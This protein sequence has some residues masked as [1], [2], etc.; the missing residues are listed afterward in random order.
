MDIVIS[1]LTSFVMGFVNLLIFPYHLYNFLTLETFKEK[2]SVFVLM[3]QSQ[4]FFYMVVA[5]VILLAGLGVYRRSILRRTVFCLE[6]FSVKIGKIAAWFAIL[7][8]FQQ[9]MIIGMGQIF[10]GNELVF[11]PLGII[12]FEGELQW[13]SGQLKFYN[14]MLIAV[15]SGYT[16]IEGGHVRVDLIYAAT[17]RR[18]QLWIDMIGTL[19]MFIPSTVILWWFAWPLAMNS[20]FS[21]RPLNIW[22]SGARWRDFK[23]ESSGTAEFS[24]VWS[25]KLLI[26]VFAGLMFLTAIAFL[27]RNLLALLEPKED[28]P[29]HYSLEAD[30]EKGTSITGLAARSVFIYDRKKVSGDDVKSEPETKNQTVA[31]GA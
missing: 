4:S 29:S 26:V 1:L 2:M 31:E 8:M 11:A 17:K 28:I 13:F 24:W 16:F 12:L 25:F 27:L 3:G 15:A 9:V 19:G 23:W 20:M 14:A 30:A 10:R 21:Q 7:M 22:S 6:I 18:T 5:L